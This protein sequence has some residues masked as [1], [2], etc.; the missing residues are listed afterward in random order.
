MPTEKKEQEVKLIADRLS[1]CTIAVATDYRGIR[2]AEMNLLRSRLREKDIE[3]RVVKNTLALRAAQQ[4]GKEL[5]GEFLDGPTALAF[6]YDEI[7][8]APKVLRSHIRSER[9]VLSIKGG[10]MDGQVLAAAQ[11]ET[12]ATLPTRDQLIA[13]SLAAL[14]GPLYALQSVLSS[15]LRGLVTALNARLSQIEENQS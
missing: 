12:L 5:L 1:R 2:T 6:G 11:V 4:E 10:L 9:S 15:Q 8:E 13:Q 7:T 14:Q 3:Y